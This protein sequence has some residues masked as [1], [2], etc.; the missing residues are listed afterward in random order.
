MV[1]E[2]GAIKAFGAGVLSS[3][4]ELEHMAAGRAALEPFDPFKPQPKMSYK[5]GC[6]P[7]RRCT[8]SC[9]KPYCALGGPGWLALLHLQ[10]P[11]CAATARNSAE[12]PAMLSL[13]YAGTRAAT[14]CWTALRRVPPSCAST[15][16]RCTR[17]C[18]RT[19]S[20]QWGWR[21]SDGSRAST[22][23]A[24]GPEGHRS[25]TVGQEL[26]EQGCSYTAVGC[27]SHT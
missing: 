16:P 18:R 13:P 4:G 12:A 8:A 2:G 6:V 24:Q 10:A 26:A 15:A 25:G 11:A 7:V 9:S 1:R 22:G 3:Y 14:L 23:C 19:S 17:S 20:G 21:E 5:D 27:P